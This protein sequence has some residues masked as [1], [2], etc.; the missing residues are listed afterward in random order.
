MLQ[1]F[2]P[3]DAA[4]PNRVPYDYCVNVKR[5]V[6]LLILLAV[7][8][9][10]ARAQSGN[11]DDQYV[12]IYSLMQQA[13][14]S[15]SSGQ[16]RQALAQ[17]LQVQADLQR[18]GKIYPD[19]N[20]RIVN[21][22]LKYLA[23]K[24]VE[25]TQKLPVTNLAPETVAAPSAPGAAPAPAVADLQAQIGALHEQM[26]K[27]QTDNSTLQSKLQEALGAQP[28]AI[29]SRELARAQEKIRS[30]M[31]EN[32]LLRV[33]LSQGKTGPAPGGGGCNDGGIGRF[34]AGATG[35]GRGKSKTGRANGARRQTG[36][37]KPGAA[38]ARADVAGQS[39]GDYRRCARK[40]RCSKSRSPI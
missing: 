35:A 26:Q 25:V 20:P 30:L 31:K 40:T 32:D 19:W 39:R 12:I 23:E 18:F 8:S 1:C 7:L 37:G 10:A 2:P 38:I 22:R 11:P 5:L 17:Y 16:P 4:L 14:S 36:P 33:S 13:D 15:D 29:D 6:A 24:I 27:M 9:P 28:A 3:R 21:F 34:A